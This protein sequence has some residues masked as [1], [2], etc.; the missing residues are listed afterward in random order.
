MEQLLEAGD[1]TQ[2]LCTI[3]VKREHNLFLECELSKTVLEEWC[4]NWQGSALGNFAI[5]LRN[6][7]AIRDKLHADAIRRLRTVV[8]T[9]ERLED[10]II[11]QMCH[12]NV[13]G[14]VVARGVP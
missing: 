5:A 11:Q 14:R 3:N 9:F 8:Q 13:R 6:A 12:V 2:P 4:V 10:E 1:G 7:V